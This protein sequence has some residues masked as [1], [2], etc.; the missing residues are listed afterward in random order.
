[1]SE[2][3]DRSKADEYPLDIGELLDCA[4]SDVGRRFPGEDDFI[5]DMRYR[6]DQYGDDMYLSEK[7][8]HWLVTIA[9]RGGFNVGDEE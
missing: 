1:M 5:T 6:Y 7:Q 2:D 4:E 8:Y 3:Y 9:V